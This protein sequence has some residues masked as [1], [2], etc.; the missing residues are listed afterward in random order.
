MLIVKNLNKS[1][2]SNKVL[3][4]VSFDAKPGEIVVIRGESGAGK[5]TLIRCICNLEESDHG[6][7]E[8]D[9]IQMLEKTGKKHN[10]DIYQDKVGLVFQGY[11]LFPH[12]S[13][14]DNLT[15]AVLSQKLMAKDEAEQKAIQTLD[16]LKIKDKADQYPH[17][18]SGGQKQRV[19]IARAI[20]LNPSILCFDEP[21]SALDSKTTEGVAEIIRQLASD[22]ICILIIT[23]DN[24]FADKIATRQLYMV[25]SKLYENLEEANQAQA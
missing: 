6:E 22:G 1:F 14:K 11:N 16:K 17:Q 9:K 7:I 19:A 12:L 13:I 24:D 3:T 15:V 10:A 5:T 23:H 4:D 8:I 20:M 21:T 25:K 18:L 2:G